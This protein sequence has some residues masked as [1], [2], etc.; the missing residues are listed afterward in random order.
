MVIDTSYDTT[1]HTFAVA[2]T[3]NISNE[4]LIVSQKTHRGNVIPERNIFLLFL[5]SLAWQTVG[6]VERFFI[7]FDVFKITEWKASSF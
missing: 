6:H 2:L 3:N 7:V 1:A 4:Q 5:R